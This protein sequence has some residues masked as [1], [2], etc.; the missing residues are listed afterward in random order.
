[1]LR[2]RS[3]IRNM[4]RIHGF[5]SL[6]LRDRRREFIRFASSS[7]HTQQGFVLYSR[8]LANKHC[9]AFD[10]YDFFCFQIKDFQ[11][12][13]HVFFVLKS[14]LFAKR[15]RNSFPRTHVPK[16]ELVLFLSLN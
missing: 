5:Q 8:A 11:C 12:F 4:V 7:Q 1:M 13:F 2:E 15:H 6:Y 16:I 9:R 10:L 14:T 3:F